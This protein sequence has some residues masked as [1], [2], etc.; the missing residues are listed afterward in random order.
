M[1]VLKKDFDYGRR[2]CG[3]AVFTVVDYSMV[4]KRED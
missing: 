2:N 3:G 1:S 4:I